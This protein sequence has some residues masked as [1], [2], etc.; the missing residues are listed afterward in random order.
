MHSSINRKIVLCLEVKK[1]KTKNLIEVTG[2]F[3]FLCFFVEPQNFIDDFHVRE[4]H[5]SAT[6]PLQTQAV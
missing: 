6:V 3:A 1:G 5:A 2:F 4:Q